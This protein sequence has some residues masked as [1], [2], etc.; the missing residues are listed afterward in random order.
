MGRSFKYLFENPED[1]SVKWDLTFVELATNKNREKLIDFLRSTAKELYLEDYNIMCAV[2]AFTTD[3]KTDEAKLMLQKLK[4]LYS[5]Y[6]KD[7]NI[8]DNYI[9]IVTTEGNIEVFNLSTKLK[10][11]KEDFPDIV[12]ERRHSECLT[13]VDIVQRLGIK[14]DLVTGYIYGRSDVAKYLHCWVETF[15]KGKEVVIDYTL[16]AIVNKEGYYQMRHV[17]PINRISSDKIKDDAKILSK[18]NGMKMYDMKE[19]VVFRDE[20]MRDLEK[21]KSVIEDEER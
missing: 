21:N 2:D 10:R 18:F 11:S 17:Q 20:M 12:T 7:I 6:I 14:N 8:K 13:S 9:Q 16:N 19:Y 5:Y 15:L 3:N 1:K 4:S